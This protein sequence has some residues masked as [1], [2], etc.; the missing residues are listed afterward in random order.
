[1][2]HF[3]KGSTVASRFRRIMALLATLALAAMLLAGCSVDADT[4][5]EFRVQRAVKASGFSRDVET[6][7]FLVGDHSTFLSL[8]ST[9]A[10]LGGTAQAH[11]LA[12]KIATDLFDKVPDLTKVSVNDKDDVDI[13]EYERPGRK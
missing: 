8:R 9:I 1:M 10:E 2:V 5:F 12:G 6:T 4:A 13:A 3:G 7:G 11:I